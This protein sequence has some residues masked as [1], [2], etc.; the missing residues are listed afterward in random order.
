MGNQGKYPMSKEKVHL[1]KVKKKN[2]K[3]K[4]KKKKRTRNSYVKDDQ[5]AK[6]NEHYII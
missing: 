2:K 3:R 5:T 1:P 4:T 6:T